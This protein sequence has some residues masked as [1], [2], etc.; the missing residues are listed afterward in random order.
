[1][2]GQKTA[3]R[4]EKVVNSG[5]GGGVVGW[6]GAGKSRNPCRVLSDWPWGAEKKETRVR[7]KLRSPGGAPQKREKTGKHLWLANSVKE[8]SGAKKKK[9][10][11]KRLF[12]GQARGE[13]RVNRPKMAP[14]APQ[15]NHQCRKNGTKKIGI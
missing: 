4:K 2:E 8:M 10:Q 13:D 7:K 15:T 6:V 11:E 1:L 3:P 5:G 12:S 14:A 9:K